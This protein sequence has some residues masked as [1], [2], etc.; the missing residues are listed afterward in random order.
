MGRT[1]LRM[2]HVVPSDSSDGRHHLRR[3]REVGGGWRAT[4]FERRGDGNHLPRLWDQD[5]E[6]LAAIAGAEGGGGGIGHDTGS[7][8]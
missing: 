8:S 4:T 3:R 6:A 1:T 2:S 7:P 5:S